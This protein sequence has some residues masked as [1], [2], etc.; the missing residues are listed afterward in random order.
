MNNTKQPAFKISTS[1]HLFLYIALYFIGG[2]IGFQGGWILAII[3]TGLKIIQP[4][5]H[6]AVIFIFF[7][8]C[9]YIPKNV[10][11]KTIPAICP[12]CGGAAFLKWNSKP[13]EYICT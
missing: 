11:A 8:L 6:V 13:L 1:T 12:S 5:W 3:L 7:I 10:F 9:V 2:G 4:P